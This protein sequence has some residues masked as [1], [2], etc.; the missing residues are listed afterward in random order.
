MCA[1]LVP[2]SSDVIAKR[3]AYLLQLSWVYLRLHRSDFLSL[4]RERRFVSLRYGK[5]DFTTFPSIYLLLIWTIWVIRG[6]SH[7]LM[8][9]LQHDVRTEHCPE[10]VTCQYEGVLK[11][12]PV[13]LDNLDVGALTDT[14]LVS[15]CVTDG[16]RNCKAGRLFTLRVNSHYIPCLTGKACC[17][18]S[19]ADFS[20]VFIYSYFFFRYLRR[21]LSREY[22]YV[23]ALRIPRSCLFLGKIR[24]CFLAIPNKHGFGVA[25][26]RAVKLILVNDDDGESAAW[27]VHVDVAWVAEGL[28]NVFKSLSH[29]AFHQCRSPLGLLPSISEGEGASLGGGGGE[30]RFK[31]CLRMMYLIFTFA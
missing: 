23:G 25:D 15:I 16:A 26:V 1:Y 24:S 3:L 19:S 18:L 11:P 17:V 29:A 14:Q 5:K 20:F 12:L 22:H 9:L 27:V 21:V 6:P 28:V 2:T 8:N 31:L 30:T 13:K 10:T 7:E 4:S